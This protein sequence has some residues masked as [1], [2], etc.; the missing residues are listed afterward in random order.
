MLDYDTLENLN[1]DV[2]TCRNALRFAYIDHKSDMSDAFCALKYRNGDF[3]S[4]L[5]AVTT[6]GVGQAYTIR[7]VPVQEQA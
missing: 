6:K 5:T 3:L 7:C 4:G 1:T 2:N